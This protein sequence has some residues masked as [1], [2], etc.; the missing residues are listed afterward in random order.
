MGFEELWSSNKLI[1][2]AGSLGVIFFFVLSGFLITY[3]LLHEKKTT[4]TIAVGKFYLRRILRI[5]PLYF[6]VVVLGFFIL[7]HVEIMELTYFEKHLNEGFGTKLVLYLLLLPNLALA[8]FVS[9]PHIGHL[10]SIGVEEQFYVLWPVVLKYAKNILRALL[11]ISV[12]IIIVKVGVLWAWSENPESE[13]LNVLKPFMAMTKIESMAIGGIGSW[14]L[15][16][17]KGVQLLYS[18]LLLIFS[19]AGI[20]FTVYWMPD[21]LQNATYLV[22]S[23]FFLII[24]INVSCNPNCFLKM[25]NRLFV[26]LGNISYGIYMYHM[27]VIALVLGLLRHFHYP[28]SNGIGSQLIVYSATIV[29]T[30]FVAWLSYRYFESGFLRFKSRFTLVR[31]GTPKSEKK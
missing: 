20:V 28:V 25:E 11:L 30:I 5:W 21:I 7:P 18:N 3:L 4:G 29:L 12:L 8:A 14:F 6:L 1:Y 10:W 23:V 9:M 2:E 13:L 15:F 22:Q 19:L 17:G 26:F 27:I 24:I 31:S 16:R